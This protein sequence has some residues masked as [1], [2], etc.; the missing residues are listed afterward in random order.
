MKFEEN[1]VPLPGKKEEELPLKLFHPLVFC[2]FESKP[3]MI[4]ISLGHPLVVESVNVV[5]SIVKK[6]FLLLRT[7]NLMS[8]P[9]Y[10]HEPVRERIVRKL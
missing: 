1:E 10:I 3:C 5:K 9:I 4:V 2:F 8:Y 6:A 7:I